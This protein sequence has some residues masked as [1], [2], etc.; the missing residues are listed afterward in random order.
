VTNRARRAETTVRISSTG[1][2]GARALSKLSPT[3]PTEGSM[4][5]SV[6]RSVYLIETY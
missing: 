5:A 3:L 1:N 6:S 2:T 4:P